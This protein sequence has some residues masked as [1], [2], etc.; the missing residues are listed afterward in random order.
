MKRQLLLILITSTLLF[1]CAGCFETPGDIIIDPEDTAQIV[2]AKSVRFL[3]YNMPITNDG[4]YQEEYM[5]LL[6]GLKEVGISENSFVN[7]KQNGDTLQIVRKYYPEKTGNIELTFA[8][9]P[10]DSLNLLTKTGDKF[11]INPDEITATPETPGLSGSGSLRFGYK[12]QFVYQNDLQLVDTLTFYHQNT[13]SWSKLNLSQKEIL[14]AIRITMQKS[15]NPSDPMI[16]YPF[17]ITLDNK[18]FGISISAKA[19]SATEY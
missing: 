19:I 15:G 16:Y 18:N 10:A 7:T 8:K 11:F 17:Q 5:I 13:T 6:P 4:A 9:T 1:S 14:M 2:P 12:K 3:E